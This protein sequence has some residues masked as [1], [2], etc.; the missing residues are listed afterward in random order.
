MA[1]SSGDKILTLID[2]FRQTLDHL[3]AIAAH[4]QASNYATEQKAEFLNRLGAVRLQ[5]DGLEATRLGQR[6]NANTA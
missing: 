6:D 5:L 3:Q 1:L 4:S 2:I